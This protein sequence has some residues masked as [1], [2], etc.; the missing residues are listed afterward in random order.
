MKRYSRTIGPIKD[1]ELAREIEREMDEARRR[2]KAEREAR[3]H[4]R[5]RGDNGWGTA[6]NGRD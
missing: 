6:P 1:P 2:E 3:E 4:A 5:R